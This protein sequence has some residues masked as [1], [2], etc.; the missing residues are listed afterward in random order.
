[1]LGLNA[2]TDMVVKVADVREGV[3][4]GEGVCPKKNVRAV[5]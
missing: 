5:M 2:T 4:S 3:G 1:M